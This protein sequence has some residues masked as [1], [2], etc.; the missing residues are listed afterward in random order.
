MVILLAGA[1]VFSLF[2]PFVSC[3]LSWNTTPTVNSSHASFLWLP[4][5]AHCWKRLHAEK[6]F[7]TT[8]TSFFFQSSKQKPLK[9]SVDMWGKRWPCRQEANP[10][11]PQLCGPYFQT[12]LLLPGINTGIRIP[13][14][15]LNTGTDSV[16]T[17]PQ[18]N[19]HMW[20]NEL[21]HLSSLQGFSSMFL[22]FRRLDHP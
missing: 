2:T 22:F 6:L 16:W 11:R 8:F 18:V 4:C 3:P 9:K 10:L 21:L 20:V 17:S 15:F 14:Y 12:P 19:T 5:S 1:T 13:N 7:I